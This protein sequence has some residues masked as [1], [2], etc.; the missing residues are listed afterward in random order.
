MA[1]QMSFGLG[2]EVG[3]GRIGGREGFGRPDLGVVWIVLEARRREI[4]L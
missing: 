4:R 3:R 1:L 2:G